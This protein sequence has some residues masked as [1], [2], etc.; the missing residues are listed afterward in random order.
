MLPVR[1]T[2]TEE[3][4]PELQPPAPALS[5]DMP[6]LNIPATTA[7]AP[8][9]VVQFP[10]ILGRNLSPFGLKLEAWLKL[11]D[12]PYTIEPSTNLRKAP[13]GKM[14]YI[15]DEG[16]IIADTSLI[17]E[18]LKVTRGIDPDAGLS[19]R[20]RAEALALQRLFEEHLYFA[21]VHSRWLDEAGWQTFETGLFDE[22]SYPVRQL[23]GFYLRSYVRRM[24]KLQ[25]LGRHSQ[26]EIYAM[27]HAD[28][29]AVADYLDE[30]PFFMGDR[31]TTIDAVAYGF[32]AS[33]LH[34]PIETELKDIARSFSNLVAWCEAMEQGL[35]CD[36]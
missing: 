9:V 16:R 27:A 4:M 18:H 31:L 3:R 22:R 32:L 23:G 30:R 21:I 34:V 7:L 15:R 6:G 17:I 28:L 14:P 10:D 25:G 11:A 8:V 2:A 13:K 29:Q 24:L 1:L 26:R 12:I 19:P 36:R 35:H 20:E 5:M 33:I